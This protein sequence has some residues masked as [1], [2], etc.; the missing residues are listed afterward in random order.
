MKSCSIPAVICCVL[1]MTLACGCASSGRAAESERA[2]ESVQ[3]VTANISKANG[4]ISRTIQLMD[5]LAQGKELP[6]TFQQY[7][8]AVNDLKDAGQRAAKRGRDMREKRQ[9]YLAKWEKDIQSI[10]DPAIRQASAERRNDIRANYEKVTALAEEIRAAYT[11][12][13]QHL[14]EV[15]KALSLDLTPA[16]VSAI[17]PA[18]A[19][20][21]R[22]GETL[23]RK[24][25]ALGVELR[26][27]TETM[28]P[29]GR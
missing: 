27:F 16:G 10:N 1:L 12:F 26:K 19:S 13:L 23:M 7:T 4:Q 11:P 28:S 25:D 24:L 14:Q 17:A 21:K 8:Q 2:V 5:Q 9:E 22:D 3:D 20:A 18:M 15:Q 29:T 6:R